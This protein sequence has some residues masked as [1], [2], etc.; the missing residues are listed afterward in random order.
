[1]ERILLKCGCVA[2]ATKTMPDGTQKPSCFVHLCDEPIENIDL[3]GRIAKCASCG[4]IVESSYNLA[5][6]QLNG[7]ETSAPKN[8]LN[9]RN[10]T[11][12]SY[13]K[14]KNDHPDKTQTRNMIQY[15]NNQIRALSTRD[16][17]YCGCNG[18]D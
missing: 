12:R 7:D 16:L 10:A 9:I 11:L 6:F 4:K 18:W 13:H 15:L 17:F 5:F 2:N 3:T 1:M 14:M 8:L